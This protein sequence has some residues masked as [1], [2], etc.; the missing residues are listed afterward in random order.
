M[1]ERY[2]Y[3]EPEKAAALVRSAQKMQFQRRGFDRR[4]YLMDEYAVLSTGRLKLRNV[5]TRDDNFSYLDELIETL[6]RL[7]RQGVSVVPILGYC[8]EEESRDG[9][10]WMIQARA[11]GEEM[12]DDAVLMAYE[13]WARRNPSAV[14][15]SSNANAEEYILRR[16]AFLAQAPQ[17]HYDKFIS[18]IMEICECD[19]LIDFNGKSNFFYDSD[20]GF[21]F[22]DLDAHTDYKYGLSDVKADAKWIAALCG[23]APCHLDADSKVFAHIALDREAISQMRPERLEQLADA[24]RE[25]FEK[26]KAAMKH[27]AISDAEIG[28]ALDRIHVFGC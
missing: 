24:N 1:I 19:I 17:R 14:Y 9:R 8:C 4:A 28:R 16:T 23:F 25:I 2:F 13:V 20:V 7:R 26:C 18:D 10:G 27:N 11:K 5:D 3:I 21:Q 6:M 12:Y 15:L 22:I